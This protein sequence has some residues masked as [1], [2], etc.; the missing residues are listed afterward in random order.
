MV[1]SMSTGIRPPSARAPRARPGPRRAAGPLPALPDCPERRGGV[2]GQPGDQP[3]DDRVG[4][5]R[6][7]QF[8][9]GA[10]HADIGQAVPA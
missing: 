7:E 1:A 4:G 3:G 5:H 8:R 2:P 6:A 9:L 10:Q